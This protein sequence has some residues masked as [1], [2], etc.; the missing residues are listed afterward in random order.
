MLGQL[1]AAKLPA[2]MHRSLSEIAPSMTAAAFAWRIDH[3]RKVNDAIVAATATTPDRAARITEIGAQ[4]V[5]AATPLTL[6]RS[7]LLE[8]TAANDAELVTC[9]PS[10]STPANS[11]APDAI[12]AKRSNRQPA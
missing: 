5:R 12:Y 4:F 1:A 7:V 10:T 11:L 8:L 3:A 9:L 6:V 2:E